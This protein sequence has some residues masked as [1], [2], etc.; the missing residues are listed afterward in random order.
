MPDSSV[1]PPVQADESSRIIIM[2]ERVE[3]LKV[4]LLGLATGLVIPCMAWLV[5]KFLLAPIFCREASNLGVCAPSDLTAY[6]IAVII[7]TI[8]SVAL[9][10]NWQVF[11]PL[12]I[13]VAAASALWG[14]QRYV[15]DTVAHA[16]WEYYIS[17]AV[18]YAVVLLLFYWL[19]RLRS[20]AFSVILSVVAV[21]LIRW[22]LLV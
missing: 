6:Y 9:M 7:T 20:F 21:I 10:A 14:L 13:A 1:V 4:G 5:Q 18:M 16:G 12:L 15:S 11:R 8:I 22:A 3:M 17:S 19:L 2:P